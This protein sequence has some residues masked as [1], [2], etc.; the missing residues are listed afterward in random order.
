MVGAYNNFPHR[1][2]F[3]CSCA[4]HICCAWIKKQ[5][6]TVGGRGTRRV[7]I[8]IYGEEHMKIFREVKFENVQSRVGKWVFF[9]RL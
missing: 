9:S 5:L 6:V 8:Y 2:S 4:D 1:Q 7:K 3:C